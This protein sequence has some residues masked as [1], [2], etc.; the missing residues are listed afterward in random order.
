MEEEG[1]ELTREAVERAERVATSTVAY[2]KT[3]AALARKL[4]EGTFTEEQHQ[5]AVSDL[6]ENWPTYARLNVSNELSHRAGDLAQKHALRGYDSIHW[7]APC[8]SRRGSRT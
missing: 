7:R 6:D 1:R 8:A 4:R 2:V 5:R 3:R